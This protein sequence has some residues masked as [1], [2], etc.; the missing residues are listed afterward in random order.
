MGEAGGSGGRSAPCFLGGIRERVRAPHRFFLS[1]ARDHGDVVQYRLAPEPTYLLNHPDHVKHVLVT[2][3]ANYSKDTPLSALV[4]L[5]TPRGLVVSENPLWREQRRLLQPLFLPESLRR[6]EAWLQDATRA[7]LASWQ[8]HSERGEP[9]DIAR[10]TQALH[11]GIFTRIL[12]GCAFEELDEIVGHVSETLMDLARP[13]HQQFQESL[14]RFDRAVREMICQRRRQPN[15]PPGDLLDALLAARDPETGH[16]MDDE[17]VRDEIFA[18]LLAG[19]ES[20]ASALNW[21][22]LWL[23]RHPEIADR[24][25]AEA[26]QVL[27]ERAPGLDDLPRLAQCQR[28]IKESMRLTPTAWSFSRRALGDDV[29]GGYAIPAGALVVLSPYTLHRHPD[30][31]PDPERFDPERFTPEREAERHRYAYL[32]FGAGARRCLGEHLAGLEIGLV[33]AAVLQR[34]RWQLVPEHRVEEQAVVTLRPGNG[35]LVTL[36]RR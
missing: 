11:R 9:F 13:K 27:G 34:F 10:E 19:H 16:A 12:F 4:K 7:R 21:L 28:A 14:P 24:I 32:P 20:A 15:A 25:A 36:A 29:I 31:W 17:Q 26:A 18:L 2:H 3:G 35:I 23:G 30:F 6:F 22:W 5:V 1:L 8:A 33:A